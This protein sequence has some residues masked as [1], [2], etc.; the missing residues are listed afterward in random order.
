MADEKSA[1]KLKMESLAADLK[2]LGTADALQV[3][4]EAYPKAVKS[5]LQSGQSKIEISPE[6]LESVAGLN[7]TILE[8]ATFFN[9]SHSTMKRRLQEPLYRQAWER[10][11]TKTQRLLR[12]KQIDTALKDG[13]VTMQIWLGKQ[14]LDQKDNPEI[15]VNVYDRSDVSISID[16]FEKMLD[17]AEAEILDVEYEVMDDSGT[18]PQLPAHVHEHSDGDGEGEPAGGE[19]TG[20]ETGSVS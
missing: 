12:K 15:Q 19:A 10:G 17:D 8:A 20:G 5:T 16:D 3:M 18:T 7:L 4:N 14:I 2:E 6:E 9:V 1:L 11:R 13:N